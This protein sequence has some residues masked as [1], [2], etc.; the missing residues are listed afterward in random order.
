MA[1][2]GIAQRFGFNGAMSQAA[3]EARI[4]GWP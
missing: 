4:G 3:F 1:D 2:R